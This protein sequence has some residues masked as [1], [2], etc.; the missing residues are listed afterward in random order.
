MPRDEASSV[1]TRIKAVA[2][3]IGASL[4]SY[5]YLYDYVQ[6]FLDGDLML[7]VLGESPVYAITELYL[8]K[9]GFAMFSIAMVYSFKL[10]FPDISVDDSSFFDELVNE[11]LLGGLFVLGFFMPLY[12]ELRYRLLPYATVSIIFF[13]F[14]DAGLWHWIAIV[15]VVSSTAEWVLAHG[16]RTPVIAPLGVFYGLMLWNGLLIEAFIIHCLYNSTLVTI[17]KAS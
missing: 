1:K 6:M 10:L 16:L 5:F 9:A 12:E 13:L 4:I 2:G 17:T 3:I 11:S 8:V 7:S 14:G 15:I